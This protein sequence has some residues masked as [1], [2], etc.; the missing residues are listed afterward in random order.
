M[1]RADI[2]ATASDYVTR[3]RAATHGDAESS[4]GQIAELWSTMLRV[5]VEPYQV[6]M[7]MDLLKTV[8]GWNNPGHLDSFVDKCGYSALAG[9][10]ATK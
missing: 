1:N 5:K 10:I 2:L 8:R 7:L 9:E 3:D 6:L 4:F